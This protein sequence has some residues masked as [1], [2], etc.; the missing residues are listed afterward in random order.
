MI[1]ILK[2]IFYLLFMYFF[3]LLTQKNRISRK[4]AI[5]IYFSLTHY[6]IT[7][8]NL[9]VESCSLYSFNDISS[10]I[11]NMVSLSIIFFSV[12]I[13]FLYLHLLMFLYPRVSV[14]KRLIILPALIPFPFPQSPFYHQQHVPS[15]DYILCN[16]NVH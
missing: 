9:Y 14:P 11:S 8:K 15:H 16:Q 13:R 5:F 7:K 10:I 3:T 4:A 2:E 12:F 6:F 1:Y